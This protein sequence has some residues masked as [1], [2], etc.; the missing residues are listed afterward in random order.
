[1]VNLDENFIPRS[2]EEAMMDEEWKESVGAEAGAMIKND[3]WYESE[4]P[5]GK[6]AV[7]SR[8]IF[9][10]KVIKAKEKWK[11]RLKHQNQVSKRSRFRTNQY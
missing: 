3:T 9:T 11:L 5:K 8:W 10:I 2:Y 7:T 6:K 1:M 4:L